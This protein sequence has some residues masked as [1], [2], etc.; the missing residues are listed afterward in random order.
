MLCEV[1]EDYP[2]LHR[3]L[4]DCLALG[5]LRNSI[6]FHVVVAVDRPND[7]LFIITVYKPD[8]Q[9]WENDWRTRKR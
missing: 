8:E 5:R 6:H 9:E 7:R 4:Q 3:P 1:I 2:T